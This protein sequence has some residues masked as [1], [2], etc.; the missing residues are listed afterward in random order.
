MINFGAFSASVDSLGIFIFGVD[1]PGAGTPVIN[2]FEI[3]VKINNYLSTG[4]VYP[5]FES[6]FI[7]F[8]DPKSKNLSPLNV[9]SSEGR[10]TNFFDMSLD[11][12]DAGKIQ[13]KA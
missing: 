7:V 12:G 10:L 11:V 13:M 8:L 1:N 4:E 6:D 9:P 2:S 5:L 3:K